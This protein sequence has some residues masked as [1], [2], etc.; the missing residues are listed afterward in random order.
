MEASFTENQFEKP[1]TCPS[2]HAFPSTER[3]R[4]IA[5]GMTC[6]SFR[7]EKITDK[8]GDPESFHCILRGFELLR[9]FVLRSTTRDTTGCSFSGILQGTAAAELRQC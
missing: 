7:K 3:M 6:S 5:S 1:P 2:A 9:P 4:L 8:L